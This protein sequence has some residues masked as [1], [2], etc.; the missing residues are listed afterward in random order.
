MRMKNE[1]LPMCMELTSSECT[2]CL[3]LLPLH[4]ASSLSTF[5]SNCLSLQV[6]FAVLVVISFLASTWQARTWS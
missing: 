3:L 5:N 2:A 1:W 6:H 4:L